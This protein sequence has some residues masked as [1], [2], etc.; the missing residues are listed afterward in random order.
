MIPNQ[1]RRLKEL[2]RENTRLKKLVA[3]LSLNKAILE[4]ALGKSCES[5][6]ASRHGSA[7][8]RKAGCLRAPRLHQSLEG[9]VD[10]TLPSPGE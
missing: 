5:N 7:G 10:A 4:E 1:A 6:L 2:E 3:D 9:A 8:K